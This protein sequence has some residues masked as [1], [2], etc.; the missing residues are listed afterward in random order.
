MEQGLALLPHSKRV[1]GSN[2]LCGVCMFS[3]CLRGFS[4]GTPASSHTGPGC[5][6][7]LAQWPPA[8]LLRI[9]GIE[10]DWHIR[11][12]MIL[13]MI[14]WY[15]VYPI[16]VCLQGKTVLLGN[17]S[18]LLFC[19]VQKVIMWHWHFKYILKLMKSIVLICVRACVCTLCL[20]G[21]NGQ[22]FTITMMKHKWCNYQSP[23]W[24]AYLYHSWWKAAVMG[25]ITVTSPV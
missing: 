20:R 22:Q 21:M 11:A 23:D 14:S 17:C 8:T 4:P 10:N 3:T 6:T 25:L 15:C 7:P 19:E 1:Q 24:L 2:P 13:Y 5:T 9:D 18:L 16:N 12:R